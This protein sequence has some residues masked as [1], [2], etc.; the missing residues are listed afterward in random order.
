MVEQTGEVD[1]KNIFGLKVNLFV[2]ISSESMCT[3]RNG[4][5]VLVGLHLG[6]GDTTKLSSF[7]MF[8]N[9]FPNMFVSWLYGW[10][11]VHLK[12]K[13]E[14]LNSSVTIREEVG[15]PCII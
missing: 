4:R 7:E 13:Q 12:H 10:H 1:M 3:I 5:P 6:D 14:L 11:V 2:D 8:K 9:I 15:M